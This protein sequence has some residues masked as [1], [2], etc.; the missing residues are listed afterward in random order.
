[1]NVLFVS[2]EALPF[3]KT[4]G[5]GDVA[6]SLPKALK[7]E[8]VD[9]RVIISKTFELSEEEEKYTEKISEFEVPVGWRHKYTGLLKVTN[10]E[11]PYYLIDNE[12]YFKRDGLYGY[13]DDGERYAY[14]SRAVLEAIQFL[15]FKPDIIHFNDWHTAIIPF[16]LKEQYANKPD[17]KDIKTVFTIHNLKYQGVFGKDVLSELLNASDIHRNNEYLDFYGDVNF[18]K[19]GICYADQITTVSETYSKEIQ[20]DF[21]GEKLDGVLRSRNYKLKG[22]TNG[23]DYGIYHPGKDKNI[24][25]N[26][27]LRSLK[28]KKENK[29]Y[30]QKKLGLE[31]NPD[32]PMISMVTRLADMKGLDLVERVI[33]EIVG[34]DVQLVFLGTGEQHYENMLRYY[35]FKYRDKIS[36]NI[37]F[38]SKLAHQ[39]YAGS[40]M[41]LMPSLFEPCGL[42]QLIAMRYGTLPIVRETGGLKDTVSSYNEY[43]GEGNGFS[44]ATYNAHDMLFTIKKAIE[45]YREKPENWKLLMKQAMKTDNS[46]KQSAKK[47]KEIYEGLITHYDK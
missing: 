2:S 12:Y 10:Q 42:S 23:L 4:G 28:R 14:F 26:F 11:V 13:Y 27:D 40:D 43:T 3:S 8:K 24:H 1:M 22:I 36:A 6:A 9:V 16:L 5:L 18:M 39:I 31:I 33:E 44:F 35:E 19:S 20:Y 38:D 32:K 30:L 37:Q 45:V 46:W 29:M 34:E 7:H 41:F 15:D 17:Y 47:Y 25:L 21:Y